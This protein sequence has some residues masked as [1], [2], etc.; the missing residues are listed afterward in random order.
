MNYPVLLLAFAGVVLGV[1]AIVF[2]GMD[3]SPGG[4]LI[5]AA[6]VLGAVV[7]GLRSMRRSPR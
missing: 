3:D 1:L 7:F 5:G 4:Q 6:L 2:A